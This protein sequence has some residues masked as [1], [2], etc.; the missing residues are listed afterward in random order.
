M[1]IQAPPANAT[2]EEI[3]TILTQV[4]QGA[5]LPPRWEALRMPATA[6]HAAGSNQPSFAVFA[7]DSA[8]S[9]GVFTYLF[10]SSTA[11]EVFFH[12]QLPHAYKLGSNLRFRVHWAPTDADTG[13]VLWGLEYT[14]ANVSTTFGDTL[15]LEA[16]AT[17]HGAA[18][19][20]HLT[21]LGENTAS[22]TL[23]AAMLLCRLYRKG[24][25]DTYAGKAALLEFDVHYQ[26][27]EL[28]S[29]LEYSKWR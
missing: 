19:F 29:Q 12:L 20:H 22:D 18:R 1:T 4:L 26:L 15:I 17:A 8:G 3:T 25:S 10:D 2:P 7:S 9:T 13:Y 24:S 28:G 5:S 23:I 27:D 21:E 16:T 14:L 11:N 6:V